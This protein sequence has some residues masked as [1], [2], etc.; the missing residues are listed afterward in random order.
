[1]HAL[2]KAF[3]IYYVI[4]FFYGLFI[5]PFSPWWFFP[6]YYFAFPVSTGLW[7]PYL[8]IVYLFLCWWE[9]RKS[10]GKVGLHF[11][12]KIFLIIYLFG[13]AF[14]IISSLPSVIYPV[15]VSS[16]CI[17][18]SLGYLFVSI[19]LFLSIAL[20]FWLPHV[21]IPYYIVAFSMLYWWEKRK[22]KTK[23]EENVV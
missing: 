19:P 16:P 23:V 10:K 18:Y 8:A 21:A 12:F 4:L 1:M 3:L 7:I 11:A 15:L 2:V 20:I 22:R 6:I 13:L 14:A 5:I 9:K 17:P